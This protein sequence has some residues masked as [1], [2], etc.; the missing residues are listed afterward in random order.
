M[1]FISDLMITRTQ[2][3]MNRVDAVYTMIPDLLANIANE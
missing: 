3:E 1:N 2:G